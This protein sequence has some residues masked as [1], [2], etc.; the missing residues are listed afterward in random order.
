MEYIYSVRTESVNHNKQSTP[1]LGTVCVRSYRHNDK[2]GVGDA[3]CV[4]QAAT[5]VIPS[6]GSAVPCGGY[7]EM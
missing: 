7:C 4:D 6:R 1:L 5:A 3:E 2:K